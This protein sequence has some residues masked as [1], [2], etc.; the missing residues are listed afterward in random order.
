MGKHKPISA[1][2]AKVKMD[3]WVKK[4]NKFIKK[5]YATYIRNEV[6]WIVAFLYLVGSNTYTAVDLFNKGSH[7]AWLSVLLA[8]LMLAI[9]VSKMFVLRTCIRDKREHA[10]NNDKCDIIVVHNPTTDRSESW[11]K[12]INKSGVHVY[13]AD[14]ET[15]DEMLTDTKW[16]VRSCIFSGYKPTVSGLIG[17]ADTTEIFVGI[18][19]S[20]KRDHT[21]DVKV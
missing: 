14:Y 18:D 10:K 6:I 15:F 16:Y 8:V 9:A 21:V 13:S 3:A 1:E 7:A 19:L 12:K 4:I 20:D 5:K 2:R 17:N 11:V